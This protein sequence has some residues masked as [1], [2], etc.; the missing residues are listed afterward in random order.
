MGFIKSLSS[1]EEYLTIT[2]VLIP[3]P[4]DLLE[5]RVRSITS[6]LERPWAVVRVTL[7]IIFSALPNTCVWFDSNEYSKLSSGAV[8]KNIVSAPN[9]V[10]KPTKSLDILFANTFAPSA[11]LKFAETA[12]VIPV[13]TTKELDPDVLNV[14]SWLLTKGWF[15]KN[16]LFA[17]TLITFDNSPV[18]NDLAIATTVPAVNAKPTC[19][20]G[21]KKTFSFNFELNGSVFKLIVNLCGTVDTVSDKACPLPP[22]IPLLTLN[23]FLSSN[24]LITCNFSV[25]MPILLPIDILSG[26]DDT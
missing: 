3:V 19:S 4:P 21:L 15:G 20:F 2:D 6:K 7:P 1:T 24:L 5:L 10:D 16:I 26:I 9:S 11:K 8:L 17:G 12:W 13:P 25:P 22:T 18:V 14:S 23:I